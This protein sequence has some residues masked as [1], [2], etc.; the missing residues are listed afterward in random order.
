MGRRR[1]LRLTLVTIAA[2][3]CIVAVRQWGAHRLAK[4]QSAS[5]PDIPMQ[6]LDGA[7]LRLS[8]YRGKVILLDFWATWCTP[9]REE[10]PRFV[11]WQ[12]AYGVHGLQVIGVAMDDNALD[13]QKFRREFNINYP[14]V[15]GSAKLAD[16]FGGIF[17]LPANLVIARDGTV[18][19]RHIG[20]VDLSLLEREL[21][22]QLA[23]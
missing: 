1:L 7:P 13:A 12:T 22:A 16:G 14:I 17:G 8:D 2:V 3:A 15:A 19:S 23:R 10:I 18:F 11:Q 20:S 4:L 6:Q 9:C 21:T 5:A